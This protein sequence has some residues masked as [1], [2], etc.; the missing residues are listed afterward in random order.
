MGI[1]AKTLWPRHFQL[2]AN[3]ADRRILNLTMPRHRRATPVGRIAI[4]CVPPA[5]TVEDTSV[6]L[7]M[8]NEIPVLHY[9]V[10]STDSVSQTAPVGTTLAA[11]SRYD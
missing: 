3:R 8:A 4:D 7:Q 6:L 9:T 2:I 11:F 5:L 10:T 1:R